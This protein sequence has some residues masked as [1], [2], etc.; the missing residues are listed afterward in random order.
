MKYLLLL[1]SLLLSIAATAHT[2][3]TG[4]V[5]KIIDGDTFDLRHGDKVYRCRIWG[6]DA[7]ELKQRFGL[8][9]RS[10]LQVMIKNR[11]VTVTQKGTSYDRKVVIVEYL[12]KDIGLELIRN[13]L[14]W[15]SKRYAPKQK[16]YAE[17]MKKAINEKRGLW[18]DPSPV[19]PKLFRLYQ[20]LA[21]KK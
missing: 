20:Q 3:Y 13:G 18:F 8:V 10:M 1:V 11:Q 21:A 17:A 5:T 15:W 12:K 2:S 7:P 9:A 16:N 4:T 14:A 6:I 19:Q